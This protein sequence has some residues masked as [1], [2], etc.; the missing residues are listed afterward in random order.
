MISNRYEDTAIKEKQQLAQGTVQLIREA[1]NGL[2]QRERARWFE[3]HVVDFNYP[4]DEVSWFR[5]NFTEAENTQLEQG[6]IIVLHDS[7]LRVT[8]IYAAIPGSDFLLKIGP[9][10]DQAG[11]YDIIALYSAILAL[12]FIGLAVFFLVH[13]IEVRLKRLEK[14]TNEFAHGDLHVRTPV[15]GKDAVG[16]LEETFNYMA[17]RIVSLIRAQ[18]ELTNAVSHELRTPIARLRFGLDMIAMS[19]SHD[20]Q[21]ERLRGMDK[22]LSDLDH[23]IDELLM[24]ARLGAAAPKIQFEPVNMTE[25]LEKVCTNLTTIFPHI[26][27]DWDVDISAP[28]E[29]LA[30]PKYLQRAVHNLV[31]NGSRYAKQRIRCHFSVTEN[32]CVVAIEDDGPGIPEDERARVFSPFTRLDDSRTRKTGGYGLG[33]AIVRRIVR[34]HKGKIWI[35]TSSMNGARFVMTWPRRLL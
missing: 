34:W 14:T 19:T 24:Y 35:E 25:M 5:N 4:I 29:V 15:S 28:Q 11:E 16:S 32:D 6:K 3:S 26:Q 12:I 22:D 1:L 13:P 30:E 31:S 9:I 18:Q 23:L 17:D 21:E 20:E 7:L 10:S 27:Y 33:L 8:E 2:D